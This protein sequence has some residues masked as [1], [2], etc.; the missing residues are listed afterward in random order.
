M[1]KHFESGLAFIVVAVISVA[2]GV[3]MFATEANLSGF[4]FLG[5]GG[6]WFIVAIGVRNKLKNA[7]KDDEKGPGPT[8]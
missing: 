5:A 6:L 8:N 1:R 2:A 7:K 4:I 3:L